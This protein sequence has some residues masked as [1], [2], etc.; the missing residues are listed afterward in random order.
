MRTTVELPPDLFRR[1]KARA[2][3]RGES[4]KKLLTRAVAAELDREA[5][6][7]QR[8]T[9]PLFGTAGGP[10]AR[11][12]GADVARALAA[13]DVARARPSRKRR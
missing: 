4:L 8:V 13:D 6:P 3:S 7:R 9:V 5:R 12:T 1:A 2:A 11:M 10:A